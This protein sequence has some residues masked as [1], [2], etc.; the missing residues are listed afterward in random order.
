VAKALIDCINEVLKR[1]N[2]ISGDASALTTLVDS[3]RQHSIDVAIQVINEGMDELYSASHVALPK[4]GGETTIT[5]IA[6]QRE[7]SLAS[8]LVLLRWPMIDRINTQFIYEYGGGYDEL[9]LLDPEQNDTGLPF[10]GAISPINGMMHFDRTPT[11]RDAGK[12]YYY[13]YDRDV[14]MHAAT[15][16]VPFTDAVFRAMVPA[17]V[18]LWKREEKNE[19]D[20]ALFKQAIGRAARFV[21]QLEQRRSYSPR[22]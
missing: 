13:E 10:W 6:G 20:Q 1:V 21:T 4:E 9:L 7:Y 19:F 17:W 12:V 18:Q 15:D 11:S 14:S 8:D 5:L 2:V 3:P 16:T 22:W